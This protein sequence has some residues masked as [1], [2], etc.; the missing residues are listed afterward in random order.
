MH[1]DTQS[2]L[3]FLIQNTPQNLVLDA[4]ALNILAENPTWLAFLPPHSILTPHP[5]ELMRMMGGWQDE[6]ECMNK[7]RDFTRR[8]NCFLLLKG[9]FSRIVS[10]EGDIY[11]NTTGN[12]AMASAGM[13]DALTGIVTALLARAYS[14]YEALSIGVFVHGLAADLF[15]ENNKNPFLLASDLISYL[16]QAF[17]K[18]S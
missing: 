18:L 3:K 6:E 13:G 7:M 11:F 17:S 12:P 5:K 14:P 4:D 1:T 15:V 16:G 10:P 9:A 8:Y 2:M